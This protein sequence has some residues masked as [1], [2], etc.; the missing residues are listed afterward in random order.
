MEL[1]LL[2]DTLHPFFEGKNLTCCHQLPHIPAAVNWDDP[3]D[4]Q[5]HFCVQN[6]KEGTHL[7][8]NVCS[9]IAKLLMT[10]FEL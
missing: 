3:R 1:P 8:Q 9:L 4:L 7:V 10:N 6:K 5:E 2:L